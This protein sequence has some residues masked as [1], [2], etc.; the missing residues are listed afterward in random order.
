MSK[1]QNEL[2][3]LKLGSI[4]RIVHVGNSYKAVTGDGVNVSGLIGTRRRKSTFEANCALELY[5]AEVDG[6]RYWKDV[7][8]SKI[9][10][11]EAAKSVD[12]PEDQKEMMEFIHSSYSLPLAPDL[13]LLKAG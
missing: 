13:P 11:P 12:I 1:V 9:D 5:E 6:N 3:H 2:K 7:P 4:A 8:L 10:I